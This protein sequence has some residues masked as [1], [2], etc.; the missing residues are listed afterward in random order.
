MDR[1]RS[2]NS[3]CNFMVCDYREN[4]NSDLVLTLLLLTIV[5]LLFKPTWYLVLTL[6]VIDLTLVEIDKYHS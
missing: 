1:G 5:A 3:C 6:K 4:V 2:N